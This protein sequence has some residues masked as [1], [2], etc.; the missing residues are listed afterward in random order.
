M[1]HIISKALLFIV[2][3]SFTYI[4]T[5]CD[6]QEDEEFVPTNEWQ[7]IKT[8]QK[9]P[10]GL[11]YRIN[12]Q[13]GT[14]EAKLLDNEKVNDRK[15]L[16]A[17]NVEVEEH[18]DFD[19]KEIKEALKN[20][21][22]DESKSEDGGKTKFRSYEE[23]KEDLGGVNLTSKTDAEII[24]DLLEE[25]K[26]QIKNPKVDENIIISILEDLNY[27][28]HQFDNALEFV[29]LNGFRDVIYKSLNSS[30]N[31]IQEIALRLLGSLVQNN[32]RVQIHALETSSLHVLLRFL[33]PDEPVNLQSNAVFALGCF[34][35]RFPL[36]QQRF[37]ENGGIFVMLRLFEKSTL[38]IQVKIITLLNDLFV[39]KRDS[40]EKS[41]KIVKSQYE[42]V[43]LENQ[44]IDQNWCLHLDRALTIVVNANLDDHDSIEKILVAMKLLSNKCKHYDREVLS[45]LRNRYENLAQLESKGDNF[46]RDISLI[47]IHILD[48]KS[49]KTEL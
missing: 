28:A 1:P 23:L 22:S 48:E 5:S 4:Q 49:T 21:K 6:D 44:F 8:G 25:H 29:R 47:C 14:K 32:A 24:S 33:S 31:P 46:Y 26:N 15:D 10:Q 36:A 41:N 13:T 7:S 17:T 35:R 12:L 39:E 9:V 16:L 2:I 42:S 45:T 30:S 18:K 20:L 19:V 3:F 27:L 37:V 34:L 43:N 38:K 11:H 40:A